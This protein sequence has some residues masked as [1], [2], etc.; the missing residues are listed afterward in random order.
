MVL[1]NT[2][3]G[4]KR[5][6]ST[7]ENKRRELQNGKNGKSIKSNTQK[8]KTSQKRI[9]NA[10]KALI[11]TPNTS[12]EFYSMD[13]NGAPKST[14]F[15]CQKDITKSP[16]IIINS[17]N[18]HNM[19]PPS[20]EIV[21]S[22]DKS[23][24]SPFQHYP[25]QIICIKCLILKLK[26]KKKTQ[27][28]IDFSYY[29]LDKMEFPL[30]TEDWSLQDELR[31]LTSIEKLGLDNW[32][33]IAKQMA[34]KG[35]VE[36][37]SHYY[38]FYYKSKID[39]S[40]SRA[41]LIIK[42][43]P[44]N[45]EYQYEFD[46]ELDK[47]NKK[48]ENSLKEHIIHNQGKVPEFTT[49]SN[50]GHVLNRSRSLIKNRNKKKND[51]NAMVTSASE[52]LGYWPKREE[53][54]IEYLNDAELE[55]SELEFNDDD[56]EEEFKA[57]MKILQIYN[58]QLDER[59]KRKKFVI[60]RNLF[61]IKKQIAFERKLSKEDRDIYNC[62][63]PFARFIQNEQFH[64]LFEGFIL[65]KNLKLRLNQLNYYKNLGCKTYEDI[66]KTIEQESKKNNFSNNKEN[67]SSG[68]NNTSNTNSE[69]G[70]NDKN[71]KFLRNSTNSI[72]IGNEDK[73]GF[74]AEKDFIKSIGIPKTIYNEL[75]KKIKKDVLNE[76]SSKELLNAKILN[77]YDINKK[78]LDKIIDYVI[79]FQTFETKNKL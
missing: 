14:C 55:L 31:L 15:E 10:N 22:R 2:Y 29:V 45:D 47:K 33:D 60:E 79:E 51:Q 64:E 35:K 70:V 36:C 9:L 61:D 18:Q 62:L 72:Q 74:E 6:F 76:K 19:P 77:K 66:Q 75:K 56:T 26:Q 21:S 3:L 69:H 44:Y 73:S 54:D 46:E 20:K 28:P 27:N 38:T 25:Y 34:N 49:N 7:I 5:K 53:F 67:S 17:P 43:A 71:K 39:K 59:V 40:P 11:S 58:S 8:P 16:K 63:K 1:K 78:T 37:E 32:E 23:K 4:K 68:S 48:K 12:I 50:G 65:E 57:K 41:D 13:I 52:I 42:N 24:K 30:F